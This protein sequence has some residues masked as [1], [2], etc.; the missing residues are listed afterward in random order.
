VCRESEIK[1][2]RKLRTSERVESTV[3]LSDVCLKVGKVDRKVCVWKEAFMKLV[4]YATVSRES[5]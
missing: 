1:E 2:V 5:L 4:G 3:N